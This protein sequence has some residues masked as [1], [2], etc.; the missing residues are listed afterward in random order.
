MP[1]PATRPSAASRWRSARS[2]PTR[3]RRPTSMPRGCSRTS[4]ACCSRRTTSATCP[5]AGVRCTTSSSTSCRRT[6][7]RSSPARASTA[8]RSTTAASPPR[9]P[10][11]RATRPT[12][13]SARCRRR[14]RRRSR[15]PAPRCA[16]RCSS[17]PASVDVRALCM[18]LGFS[19]KVREDL[20]LV[21]DIER[22]LYYSVHSFTTP[23][24]APATR[25]APAR[26]GVPV[27]GGGGGR[28]AARRPQGRAGRRTRHPLPRLARRDR[29]RAHAA[30]RPRGRRAPD[31]GEP[32]AHC[33]RCAPPSVETC[34]SR[35]TRAT[36]RTTCRRSCSPP[37]WKSPTPSPQHQPVPGRSRRLLPSDDRARPRRSRATD[38]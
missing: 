30:Q 9:S 36:S 2:T 24:L 19:R 7:A 20:A 4:S 6:A 11:A 16:R 3:A 26:D 12:R 33:C 1:T 21:F 13:S 14:T 8:S 28:N 25:T 37:R 38:L 27:A 5:A 15:R 29:R 32:Q 17:G 22:D 34:T 18:D 35:A 10:P 23:D 31:A